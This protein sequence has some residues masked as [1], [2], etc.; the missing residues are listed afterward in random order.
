MPALHQPPETVTSLFRSVPQQVGLSPGTLI[1]VGEQKVERSSI[2]VI[3]YDAERLV[4]ETD[5][6]LERCLELK[7]SPSVSWINLNGIHDISDIAA[8]GQ[9]FDLHSLALEDILNTGHRPKIEEFDHSL[10][11]ILK[12][13]QFDEQSNQTQTEQISLVLTKNNVLSFQERP[14]DVFAGVRERLMRKHGRI[15]QRGPDY[16]TY[17]LFDSIVDSYFH[18]LEKIGDR[19][20]LLEQELISQPSQKTLQQVHNFKGQLILLRKSVWP[21]RELV[22]SM[23]QDESPLIDVSTNVYLRDLSDHIVQIFETLETFRDTASGL[24]DLYMSSISHRTNEVMQV[25][26]IMAALFI[27]LTF[28]AGIYGM[29]F[30]VMPEL[31]WRYGYYLVWAVM[32]TCA[33]AM[34][35]YFRKKK[36]F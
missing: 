24:I 27:P 14:G 26:T 25:L 2:D 9:A 21:L 16:L 8:F 3:D 23:L 1:H 28:I 10:L 7:T 20:E 12:M 11:I 34:L 30:E 36:W 15:R 18:V 19:L 17:A 5:V 29:N 4:M 13:L 32:I 35:I 22:N 33:S 31:K 6:T